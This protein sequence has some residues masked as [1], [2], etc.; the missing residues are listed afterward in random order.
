MVYWDGEGEGEEYRGESY[1][2]ADS[3][4]ENREE[5]QFLIDPLA[6]G[7]EEAEV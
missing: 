7:D 3:T 1:K 2:G 5:S 6:A 4:N